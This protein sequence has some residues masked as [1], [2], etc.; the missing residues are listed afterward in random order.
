VNEINL[1]NDADGSKS[2][3]FYIKLRQVKMEWGICKREGEEWIKRA[4]GGV[5]VRIEN[6]VS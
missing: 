5:W 4:V 3:P 2:Y 6:S 1:F